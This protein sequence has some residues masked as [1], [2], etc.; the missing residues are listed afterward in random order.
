M[1]LFKAVPCCI[2]NYGIVMRVE[3]GTV[4]PST[5][6]MFFKVV[7]DILHSLRFHVSFKNLYKEVTCDYKTY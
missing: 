6:C 3:V 5:L 4:S 7:L 1:S 2:L